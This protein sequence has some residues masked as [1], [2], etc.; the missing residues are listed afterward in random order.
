MAYPRRV[1]KPSSKP[2]SGRVTPKASGRYTPPT[3]RDAKVSP[4]WVPILMFASLAVGTLVILANYVD[5]LPG[6]GANN[7]YLLAGLA[8]IAVGFITSTKYR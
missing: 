4:L 5:L 3:P 8:L 1:A 6:D 2:K 7:W